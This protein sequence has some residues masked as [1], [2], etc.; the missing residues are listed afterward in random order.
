MSKAPK[1]KATGFVLDGNLDA[2]ARQI[3]RDVRELKKQ[4]KREDAEGSGA[5][6][7]GMLAASDR[8]R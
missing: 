7:R 8:N 6:A 5:P 1:R 4:L 3:A 2:R